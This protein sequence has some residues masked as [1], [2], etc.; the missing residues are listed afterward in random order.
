[1]SQ[2]YSS[3]TQ[4]YLTQAYS[5]MTVNTHT[6]T[7]THTCTN[8][9][10][11]CTHRQLWWL[12]TMTNYPR[13]CDMRQRFHVQS[14]L[15]THFQPNKTECELCCEHQVHQVCKYSHQEHIIN[16]KHAINTHSKVYM[17][18]HQLEQLGQLEQNK[19]AKYTLEI[20]I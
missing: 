9:I 17:R 16:N 7:H 6:H 8:A 18:L 19:C 4:A 15:A 14:R 1:M 20:M 12:T 11:S 13:L 10:S 2:E 3:M 5:S